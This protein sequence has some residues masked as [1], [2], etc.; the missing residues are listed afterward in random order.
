MFEWKPDYSIKIQSIDAQHKVLF[1]LASEL[2]AA[3]A[4]GQ[5]SAALTSVLD[6]LVSYTVAHFSSEEVLM[7]KYR[8]PRL[9]EHKAEHE[10]LTKKV[11]QIR[12]A[13]SKGQAVLTI[14]VMDF[15][16]NWLAKHIKHSDMQYAEYINARAAA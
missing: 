12:E 3:M 15:L 4:K 6:R 9:A 8:Y 7:A 1:G 2:N 13:L 16:Q 11:K 5:G 10:A 14:D